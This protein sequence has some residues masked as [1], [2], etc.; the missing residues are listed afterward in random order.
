MKIKSILFVGLMS[1][2]LAVSSIN[3]EP[4]R[5]KTTMTMYWEAVTVN[6]DETPCTDLAGYA[7]YR[8]TESGNWID[9]TGADKAYATVD[10]T[11]LQ[12]E[13]ICSE[14][15]LF[16]WVVRAFDTTGNYGDISNELETFIDTSRPNKVKIYVKSQP[17]VIK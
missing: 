7:L 8:S 2:L 15:G 4:L 12:C 6:D 10:A 9:L 17:G 1:I 16:Y 5:Y 13:I 11:Q 3:A 14:G